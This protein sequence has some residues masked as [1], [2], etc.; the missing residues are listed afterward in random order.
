MDAGE[1]VILRGAPALIVAHAHKDDLMA[2][3]SC[4]IELTHL[5]LA[6]TG[7]ELGGCWA[8]YFNAAVSSFPPIKK[9]LLLP[10]GHQ[11]FGAMMIGYPEFCFQRLVERKSPNI[12]WRA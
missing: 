5:K 4:T 1:E 10:A 12:L 9:A 11:C 7:M 8:G 2:P 3:A 6:T